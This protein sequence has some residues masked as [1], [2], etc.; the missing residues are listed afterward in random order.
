MKHGQFV[1][2]D[3]VGKLVF[4]MEA[5]QMQKNR[6][7]MGTAFN[8]EVWYVFCCTTGISGTLIKVMPYS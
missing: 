1:L 2:R 3:Q 7:P 5:C 4:L 8:T 6:H